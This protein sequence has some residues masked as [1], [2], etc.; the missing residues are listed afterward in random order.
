MNPV[1]SK[2]SEIF[3]DSPEASRTSNGM[4]VL[5]FGSYDPGYARNRV[6]ISGLKK[7]GVEVIE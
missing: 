6:L 2:K 7:N 4:K 3:A 5:Y 1:R